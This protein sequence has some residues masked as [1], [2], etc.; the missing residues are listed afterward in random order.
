M[1]I[2]TL[3]KLY[4]RDLQRLR[5]EI[6]AYKNEQKLW[7]VEKEIP[8]S[9]GNL[10]LHL[11][12]NL[13]AFIGAEIGQTDYVRDRPTEFSLKNIPKEELLK[14]VDETAAIIDAALNTLTEAQLN[15]EY[16][17]LVF[18]EKTTTGFLLTHLLAHLSYHLGQINYHRRLLDI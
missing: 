8:N 12:G 10:C 3:K 18:E 1:L 9:A 5:N 7:H 14:Q 16:P 11:V 2:S 13:N 4:R 15:E 17:L 6:S